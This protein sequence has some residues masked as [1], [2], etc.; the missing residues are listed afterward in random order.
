MADL[1]NQIH[2]ARME[3]YYRFVSEMPTT[4]NTARAEA[5]TLIGRLQN[6]AELTYGDVAAGAICGV[7]VLIRIESAYYTTPSSQSI[8][9]HAHKCHVYNVLFSLSPL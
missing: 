5:R 3:Y 4:I 8:V 1:S 7:Q 6:P 2:N 9:A